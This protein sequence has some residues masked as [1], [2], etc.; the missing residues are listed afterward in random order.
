[1]GQCRANADERKFELG[2]PVHAGAGLRRCAGMIVCSDIPA[3]R[4]AGAPE[5]AGLPRQAADDGRRATSDGRRA[6]G[7]GPARLFCQGD[8]RRGA[9]QNFLV[10][11]EG[12]RS[13]E[14]L[15]RPKPPASGFDLRLCLCP[16]DF[17]PST[18]PLGLVSLAF[19]LTPLHTRESSESRPPVGTA[20]SGM[21]CG[22]KPRG[23]AWPGAAGRRWPGAA[24]GSC[25]GRGAAGTSRCR[26]GSP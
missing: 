2:S 19:G 21:A 1:M 14:K 25:G 10:T 18:L 26:P 11:S 16:F 17:A 12:R 8:E 9:W 4:A 22:T 23:S 6:V 7:S 13:G 5:P 3:K 20:F 15:A 24:R